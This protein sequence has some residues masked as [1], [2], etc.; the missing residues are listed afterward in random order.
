[1]RTHPITYYKPY[2][3][4]IKNEAIV[5]NNMIDY[6]FHVD[7]GFV[8]AAEYFYAHPEEEKCYLIYEVK[9]IDALIN[10]LQYVKGNM[11]QN[12]DSK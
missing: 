11:L 1:M 2:D 7:Y 9:D 3:R 4:I 5:H 12:E 6:E 8:Q 10:G